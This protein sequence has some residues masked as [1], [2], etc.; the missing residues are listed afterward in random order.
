MRASLSR[1]AQRGFLRPVSPCVALCAI[2]CGKSGKYP[3]KPFAPCRAFFAVCG[4]VSESALHKTKDYRRVLYPPIM[5]FLTLKTTINGGS[6]K[7]SNLRNQLF[8]TRDTQQRKHALFSRVSP[9]V[10]FVA[11]RRES[12]RRNLSRRVGCLSRFVRVKIFS[13]IRSKSIDANVRV[14]YTE[15]TFDKE[16]FFFD[17]HDSTD[18]ASTLRYNI[19]YGG[20]LW[21]IKLT[22]ATTSFR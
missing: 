1:F 16:A 5:N 12:T 6:K 21:N 17:G 3:T 20:T 15:H 8:T 22:K 19:C 18:F 7:S 11:K 2:C 10:R 4:A 9:C 13:N 14:C